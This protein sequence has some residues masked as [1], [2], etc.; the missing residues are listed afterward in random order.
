MLTTVESNGFTYSVIGQIDTV[1][2]SVG[3]LGTTVVL[4]GARM[5][6]GGSTAVTVSLAGIDAFVVP[7]STATEIT[8]KAV[9]SAA[10]AGNVVV[11]SDSGTVVTAVNGFTYNT[12]SSIDAVTLPCTI[13]NAGCCNPC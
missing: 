12:A 10:G 9:G 8:V 2:P 7:G 13:S 1:T 4:A 11:T 3:Q 6:G 5:L